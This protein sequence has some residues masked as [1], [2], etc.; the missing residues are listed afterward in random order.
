MIQELYL[1][2]LIY[3]LRPYKDMILFSPVTGQEIEGQGS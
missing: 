3:S 2:A 1:H